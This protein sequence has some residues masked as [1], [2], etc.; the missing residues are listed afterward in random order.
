MIKLIELKIKT[1]FI[2]QSIK[3]AGKLRQTNK[4]N[5]RKITKKKKK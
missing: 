3:N 4:Y 2:E 1:S 5:E